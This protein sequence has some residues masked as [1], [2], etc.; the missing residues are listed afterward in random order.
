MVKTPTYYVFKLF[1]DHQENELLESFLDI[2]SAAP[3]PWPAV[4]QSASIAPD[5]TVHVTLVNA[6]PDET[7][8]L[9]IETQ[10]MRPKEV[11]TRILTGRPGDHNT[12]DQPDQVAD[13]PFAGFALKD[14]GLTVTLPPCS[15]IHLALR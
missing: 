7:Q 2:P 4:Q 6:S 15:L 1:M 11:S 8:E 10:G 3:H 9:A 13:Q 5:G 12:F 14:D